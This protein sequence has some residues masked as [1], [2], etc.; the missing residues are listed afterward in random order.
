[1]KILMKNK[2]KLGCA[3]I[4]GLVVLGIIGRLIYLNDL[5]NW[6][7]QV[8]LEMPAVKQKLIALNHATLSQIPLADGVI[9]THREDWG[10]NT[11]ST[12][13]IGTMAKYQ[14]NNPELDI[15]AYYRSTLEQLGWTFSWRSSSEDAPTL[16]YH[17]GSTCLA[18]S[19][20]QYGDLKGQFTIY[21]FQDFSAQS[22]SPKLP[23]LWYLNYQ[24][25][26][27]TSIMTCR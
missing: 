6:Y 16:Q 26:G 18:I 12:Y 20:S 25:F 11:K 10:I 23:P 14:I 27:E 24:N 19:S 2:L 3:V 9:E 7:Q 21:V 5:N 17:S 8:Q 15:Q 4:A 22:F 1:M 13:G